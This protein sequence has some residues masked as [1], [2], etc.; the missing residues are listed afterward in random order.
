MTPQFNT[1]IEQQLAER[2]QAGLLRQ[3][4]AIE[5]GHQP[6]MLVGGQVFT[7]FSSNDYLGLASSDELKLTYQQAI[8]QFGV[9]SGASPLVT[10]YSAQHQ[11][12]SDALCEWL[13][14]ERAL[15][16]SS[17]FAAN[18]AALLALLQSDDLL[19]QDKL[20][21]ASLMEA[22]L[23]SPA[24]MKRYRHNDMQHFQRQIDAEKATLAVSESVFSMDGDIAPIDQFLAICK[25][26]Q[27]CSMVDDAHGIG[28]LGKDGSGCKS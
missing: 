6:A 25:Q 24:Q 16:F 21:H 23:L 15:F 12:L 13:G 7:N 26:N 27:W 22:G 20:N 5:Q 14:Y 10:G 2:K 17:G 11:S 19:I 28:V 18:Q 3:T 9:G 8:S 4:Q 1:R